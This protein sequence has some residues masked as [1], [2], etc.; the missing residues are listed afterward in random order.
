M[1]FE[2]S[3]V[4]LKYLFLQTLC[5]WDQ[6][7]RP[8]IPTDF[9]FILFYFLGL[10]LYTSCVLGCDAFCAFLIYFIQL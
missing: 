1:V 5:T 4:R 8:L 6:A 2:L 3:V 10:P 9:Y 7:D